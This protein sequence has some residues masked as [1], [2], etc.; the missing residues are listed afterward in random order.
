MSQDAAAAPQPVVPDYADGWLGG[1]VPALLQGG[2]MPLPAPTEGARAHV[3]LALDGLGWR[4]V[5][6]HRDHLPVINGMAGRPITSVVPSTTATALT[7][8]ATGA[9]PAE[10]GVLGYRMRVAGRGLNVLRWQTASKDSRPD[11]VRVQPVTPFLGQAVPVVTK[12]EF[13]KTGFTAAHLR[14]TDFRG[15]RTVSALLERVAE[16]VA[17]GHRFVYAYYDGVDKVA[18]E[19]GLDSA[20]FATELVLT[21]RLVDDLLARLP[22][23]VC[24]VLTAD[25]GQVQVGPERAVGLEAVHGMVAA[26]SGEGRFRGLHARTGASAD[27]L[28][29]CGELYGDRAWVRARDQL[30]DDGWFGEVA[31]TAEVRARIGDVVLA[32]HQPVVFIDPG[33]E[34][35][36]KMQAQHGSLTEAE[37]RVPLLAACGRR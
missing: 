18:H 30:F 4:I 26:Y 16:A 19:Y 35:E 29:A 10:H 23:D 32:A 24:L 12:A 22:G 27:L 33:N 5:G 21:D 6:D 11:P 37:M 31:P 34:N 36:T 15:W 1:L 13:R 7:S 25:H 2:A 20:V 14:D 3:V 17:Q 8:L 28:A 9:A